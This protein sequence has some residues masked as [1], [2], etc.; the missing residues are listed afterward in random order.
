MPGLLFSLIYGSQYSAKSIP[1]LSGRVMIVSGGNRGL[2]KAVVIHLL[3]AGAK[4]YM[5]CRSPGRAAEAIK[6]IE[7]MNLS[8]QVIFL[9]LDLMDFESIRAAAREF[10]SAEDHLDVLY[11]NAGLA[12]SEEQT[13]DADGLEATIKSNHFGPFLLTNLLLDR[14][15]RCEGS[16]VVTTSSRLYEWFTVRGDS[17]SSIERLNNVKSSSLNRYNQSKFANVLFTISLAKKHPKL[18]CNSAHPGLVSTDML[19]AFGK[20]WGALAAAF[21]KSLVV[22]MTALG[23]FLNPEEGALTQ[24]YLGTA[25]EV[26]ERQI[27]G[28]YFVPIANQNKM[29]AAATETNAEKLW[30]TTEDYFSALKIPL[31]L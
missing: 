28:K 31:S 25:H 10:S 16:R 8:G 5:A 18:L 2:G 12:H 3:R 19:Q 1:D 21:S 23:I 22:L 17:F 6:E 14:L 9:K 7:A 4:V 24:L 20:P 26:S 13:L 11:N 29:M 27:S 15:L 30:K